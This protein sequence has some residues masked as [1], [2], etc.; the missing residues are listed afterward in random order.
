MTLQL[1]QKRA[2]RPGRAEQLPLSPKQR[3][4]QAFDRRKDRARTAVAQGGQVTELWIVPIQHGLL[5]LAGRSAGRAR[6]RFLPRALEQEAQGVP[7]GPGLARQV[8]AI[9]RLAEA[10]IEAVVGGD[11]E[12]PRSA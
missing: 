10:R 4:A 2:L 9:M 1:R 7:G 11:I 12:R 5:Q 3:E 6:E 8:Q